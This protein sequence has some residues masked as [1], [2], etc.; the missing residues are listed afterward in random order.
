M[1]SHPRKREMHFALQ[2]RRGR[3][4]LARGRGELAVVSAVTGRVRSGIKAPRV[5]DWWLRTSVTSLRVGVIKSRTGRESGEKKHAVA[6]KKGTGRVV[7]FCR[8]SSD[9]SFSRGERESRRG[10]TPQTFQTPDTT[11]LSSETG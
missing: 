2:R 9:I 11:T 5:I 3:G 6:V 7:R 4:T 1:I 10:P 8:V